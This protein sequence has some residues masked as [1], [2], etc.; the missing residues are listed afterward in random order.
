VS[1][2][3]LGA[4]PRGEGAF[5]PATAMLM[6]A[7]GILAF[8]AM[9]VLGAYAPDLRSGR[10]GG[11]H[12]LSNAA[13]GFA[14]IVELARAT[15]RNPVIA[16]SEAALDTEDLVVITPDSGA[17]DLSAQL[18]KRA[19][20][21]TLLVMPKWETIADRTHSGWVREAGLKWR[22]DP[23]RILA[24]AHPLT[25][26][27]HRSA[28]T[29]L[30]TVDSRAPAEMRFIAPGALQTVSGKGVS[31]MVAD[32]EGHGVLV[33]LGD[34]PLYVLSDPD[35]LD[36]QGMADLANA[37][38]ALA[39]L[40]FLNSTGAKS[41]VFDVTANGLGRS[42]SPLKL[43]FDPPFLAT[44]LAIAAA[45]LLAGLHALVRFGAPR[46]PER[47]LAF[48]KA[49][50]I[51]NTAAL[52]RKA[53]REGSIG[54]R[55]ADMIRERASVV[56]GVPARLKDGGVDAYLDQLGGPRRFSDLAGAA[57]RARRRDEVLAAAQALHQWQREKQ[58]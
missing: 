11:A 26:A 29:P 38:A 13:T 9:L 51:D 4:S 37:R 44:T 42:R 2:L 17:T 36:N 35:L 19:A 21:P 7:V 58:G 10:N 32:L 41:I 24:P 1:D 12:A 15:G 30:R 14:G 34:E 46:R 52:V 53:R 47:A 27:R 5:R 57:A 55:Y 31:L 3:A 6:V 23:E 39:M 33:Q 18:A 20:K 48:G 54:A 22:A 49:A 40:D 8:I 25:V 56:F 45:L 16:R 50:L 28:G 43:A